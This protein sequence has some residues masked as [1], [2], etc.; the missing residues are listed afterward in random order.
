MSIKGEYVYNEN[1]QRAKKAVN[2]QT[3]YFVFDQQGKMI[4][5]SGVSTAEYVFLNGSPYAKM[6]NGPIYYIH[7]DHLGTPQKMTD[8]QK[9]L[10]WE[11]NAMPFGESINITGAATNNLRFPGQYFDAETDL[12]YNYFR[13]YNPAIGWYIQKDP[14]GLRGGINLYSYVK[15][16][17]VSLTDP[18]GLLCKMCDDCPSGMYYLRGIS[19]G[20]FIFV[21]G[22]TTA[23]FTFKCQTSNAS[24]NLT[25]RSFN[26]GGGL[27]GGVSFPHGV[28][29]GCNK[30]DVINNIS[31]WGVFANLLPA[32]I[33]PTFGVGG[34]GNY[35]TGPV[36]GNSQLPTSGG[37]L[38]VGIGAE[39]S[40]GGSYSWIPE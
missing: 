35:G 39:A 30:N 31:G 13:D 22:T 6:E 20:G 3:T 23:H 33:P 32:V 26:F 27:G 36:S 12:H 37:S 4:A 24:F 21:V 28:I 8:A 16:R 5:E 10:A 29:A 1:G 25:V 38:N 17:P 14:I 34:G 18:T 15:N 7:N 40:A 9:Q 11:I 2:G 19:Y